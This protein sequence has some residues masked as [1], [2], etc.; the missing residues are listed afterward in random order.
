MFI[1]YPQILLISSKS[2]HRMK[3]IFMPLAMQVE[4]TASFPSELVND[5]IPVVAEKYRTYAASGS[6][7]DIVASRDHRAIVGFSLGGLNS[8]GTNMLRVWY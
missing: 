8:K 1:I 3:A 6:I 4:V 5:I 7:E 2:L